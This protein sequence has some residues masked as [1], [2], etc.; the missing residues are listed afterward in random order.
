MF[1]QSIVAK[2]W[3]T[4]LLLVSAVLSILMVLLLQSFERFHLDDAESQLENQATVIREIFESY[5][6]KEAA[7]IS[8]SQM[9][10]AFDSNV[11][12]I[13]EGEEVWSSKEPTQQQVPIQYFLSDKE[14]TSVFFRKGCRHK[15][16][17]NAA[18]WRRGGDL[19]RNDGCRGI[20][21][22]RYA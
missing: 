19:F 7:F 8:I 9:A 3:F 14:L 16:G 18:C 2:L 10:S 4:I 20:T 22:V 5:E 1:W 17:G 15:R 11:V 12:I 21:S 13:V 6:D